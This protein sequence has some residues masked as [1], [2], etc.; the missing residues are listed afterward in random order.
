MYK[1]LPSLLAGKYQPLNRVEL[2]QAHLI[3]NLNLF[4]K[5]LPGF[6]IIPVLKANAYG[7]GL[8]EVAQMLKP[9]G[10][11]LLAVDGYFEAAKI[12]DTTNHNVLV[13]GYIKPQNIK[14]LNIKRC[15]FVLQD[16]ESIRAFG[17]LNKPAKIHLELN[18]GMNRLGIRPVEL[19]SYLNELTKFPKLQL[20]GVMSHLA[21]AD[22]ELN[23]SFTAAQVKL[24]DSLTAQVFKA[25]FAPK[26]IHIAQTAGSISAQSRYANAVRIGIGLYGINPLGIKDKKLKNLKPVLS[27]R[28]TIIKVIELKKGETVSYG[29]TFKAQKPMK[30]AV[31][32]LGY[33]EGI[34]RLLSNSG[35]VTHDGR[36]LSIVGRVCMNHTMIDIDNTN[37]KVG[38]EVTVISDNKL[39]P[40]SIEQIA[41]RHKL[42][43]YELLTGLSSSV[44]RE[45]VGQSSN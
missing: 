14:L 36:S 32:P 42:F 31:L 41:R 33:Y 23:Q 16:L 9:A 8:T 39:D 6:K 4:K 12:L 26:L 45:I 35:I 1:K 44:R 19:G 11:L 2:S 38:D 17:R 29:R 13:M 18:S 27:V 28:S 10:R 22:N 30:I 5:R 20:E 7:H 40:N 37:L 34:P 21:D 43:S 15:S 25:G 3:H 24:F